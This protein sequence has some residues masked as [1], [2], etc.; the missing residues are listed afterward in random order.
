MFSICSY[1]TW[2]QTGLATH[3]TN[4]CQSSHNIDNIIVDRRLRYKMRFTSFSCIN[5]CLSPQ[6]SN[7]ITLSFVDRRVTTYDD[8]LDHCH[9]SLVS[10]QRMSIAVLLIFV[11]V[12]NICH[13]FF[14]FVD[15]FVTV[16]DGELSFYHMS[17]L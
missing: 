10:E 11:D 15:K 12:F 9:L 4:L 6:I 17:F 3:H 1:D 16:V 5:Y 13:Q 14:T 2:R 8:S 7:R